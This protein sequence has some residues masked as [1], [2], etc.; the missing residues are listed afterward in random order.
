MPED[1]NSQSLPLSP[2]RRQ[3][4]R[5]NNAQNQRELSSMSSRSG[6]GPDHDRITSRAPAGPRLL[7]AP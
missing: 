4:G 6:H 2:R 7:L 1:T 3:G 5:P